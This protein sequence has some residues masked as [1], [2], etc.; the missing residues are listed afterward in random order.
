MRE[1]GDRFFEYFN[2]ILFYEYIYNLFFNA[3]VPSSTIT[4]NLIIIPP[5]PENF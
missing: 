4:T 1:G 2:V 5:I 3:V